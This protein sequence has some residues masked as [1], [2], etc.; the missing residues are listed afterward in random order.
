MKTK[1]ILKIGIFSIVVFALLISPIL[2]FTTPEANADENDQTCESQGGYCEANKISCKSGY[3]QDNSLICPSGVGKPK[4]CIPDPDAGT[5]Q[6]G[7]HGLHTVKVTLQEKNAEEICNISAN[8]WINKCM[9]DGTNKFVC[10]MQGFFVKQWCFIV[11]GV[12]EGFGKMFAGIINLEIDWILKAL[13]PDTYGGFINNPGVQTIWTMLRNIVNALLVLGFIGIAIATIVGYKKYAW[14]QILW[15]LIIVA[16]LVNFSLVIAGMIVDIS[17]YLTGYFLSISQENNESIAP[18]IMEGY[19]YVATTTPGIIGQYDPPS[20]FGV[21]KYK[22]TG[23]ISD[24]DPEKEVKSYS[25]RLGNFF[26]ISFIM[27]LVGGFAVIALL[28]IFLTIIVRNLLIIILLGLSPIVFAAWIFPDTEKYWKMWW[29]NFLKWCFFPVIFAFTLYLALTVMNKMPSIGT[30]SPMAA[31]IIQMVLFSMFL[32]GG[33]IFS[34]QGGGAASQLVMK[35]A[36]KAG[37]AAGAFIGYKALKGVTGSETWRKAQEKLESSKFAPTHDIGVWMSRQPGKIRAT[38]LKQIEEDYKGRGPDQIRADMEVHKGDRGRIAVGLNALIEKNKLETE[39]DTKFLQIAQNQ[40]NLN[41]PGLKKA[42]PELYVKFFTTFEDMNKELTQ[43]RKSMPGIS[44]NE[45]RKRVEINLI[46]KRVRESSPETI[47]SGNWDNILGR[48]EKMG[49]Q[50]SDQFFHSLLD[51]NVPPEGFAAMIRPM[52]TEK[53]TKWV[54]EFVESVQRK[55]GPQKDA[56][57]YLRN[58]RFN[59]NPFFRELLR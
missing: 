7:Q 49:T 28:A 53:Q 22:T 9:D 6:V 2:K 33:L 45:A 44:D 29:S 8:D 31:T 50:Y 26:I 56:K 30:E 42:H 21:D 43:I 14:K 52:N 4:C 16:L 35:Q 34:L 38:E 47:K 54:Q 41:V 12:L 13:K 24:E 27:I 55:I 25:L 51:K 58:K 36:T 17:N 15:K 5:T 46:S 40:P 3:V 48:L 37:A 23:I 39:K 10:E 11:K 32:V 57:D 59:R 20:I 18:R 19:G 1:N